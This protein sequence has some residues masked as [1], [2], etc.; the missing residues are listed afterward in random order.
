MYS[1]NNTCACAY[2]CYVFARRNRER[3][4]WKRVETPRRSPRLAV[5]RTDYT[6]ADTHTHKQTHT[7]THTRLHRHRG[8]D[9]RDNTTCKFVARQPPRF[10]I[11]QMRFITIDETQG[12]AC[13]VLR[14]A[15]R[16]ST[17]LDANVL[18]NCRSV[19]RIGKNYA[20]CCL[21][22]RLSGT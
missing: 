11:M 1:N 18:N 10:V 7:H 3:D 21:R 19:E 5:C 4:R 2:V 16:S 15:T 12:H 20:S 22:G 17:W 13:I 9:S 6:R 8:S 14:R